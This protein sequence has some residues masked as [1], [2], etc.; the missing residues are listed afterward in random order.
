MGHGRG[1]TL[2][3]PPST[4]QTAWW[5]LSR[6]ARLLGFRFYNWH[7]KHVVIACV[8]AELCDEEQAAARRL[9]FDEAQW[10]T[11][12]PEHVA[13]LALSAAQ[14]ATALQFVAAQLERTHDA[15]CS[16]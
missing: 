2:P 14:S 4:V 8:W 11:H 7:Q 3:P 10:D 15:E 1:A 5:Q 13:V 6:T 9:G 12:T 16:S